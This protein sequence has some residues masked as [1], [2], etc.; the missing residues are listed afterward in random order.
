M[1]WETRSPGAVALSQTG[2]G[3]ERLKV[4]LVG[5][6][7]PVVRVAPEDLREPVEI[8]GDDLSHAVA[9]VLLSRQTCPPPAHTRFEASDGASSS[10]QTASMQGF[11]AK[12]TPGLEPGTP[13]LRVKCST[14]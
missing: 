14:S 5:V 3:Q 2:P 11:P 6:E 10:A 12:P 9:P 13:S 4:E 8:G 1:M 7:L